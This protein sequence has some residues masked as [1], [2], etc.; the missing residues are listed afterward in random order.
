[1]DYLIN[2]T[3]L[4][5]IYVRAITIHSK[6]VLSWQPVWQSYFLCSNMTRQN[7]IRSICLIM[8][9]CFSVSGQQYMNRQETIDRPTTMYLY[10]SYYVAPWQPWFCFSK[11]KGPIGKSVTRRHTLFVVCCP[12]PPESVSFPEQAVA[13]LTIIVLIAAGVGNIKHYSLSLV[14]TIHDPVDPESRAVTDWTII[15]WWKTWTIDHVT[16]S[17]RW[18]LR[19]NEPKVCVIPACLVF[20]ISRDTL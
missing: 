17:R 16:I 20:K 15:T 11:S 13:K 3:C 8:F 1:M 18:K 2:M 9:P 5:N 14:I 12:K 4:L 10:V 6:I 19:Y 7:Y